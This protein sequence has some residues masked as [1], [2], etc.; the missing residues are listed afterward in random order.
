MK[1]VLSHSRTAT[2]NLLITLSNI[3]FHNAYYM[4]IQKFL[5]THIFLYCT[6]VHS[7]NPAWIVFLPCD[8]LSPTDKQGL[9]S[10]NGGFRESPSLHIHPLS[11][12]PLCL[13][14]QYFLLCIRLYFFQGECGEIR[15]C[16]VHVSGVSWAGIWREL[17]STVDAWIKSFVGGSWLGVGRELSFTTYSNFL[18]LL[19]QT[20]SHVFFFSSTYVLVLDLT[21]C[22]FSSNFIGRVTST[23]FSPFPLSFLDDGGQSDLM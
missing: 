15:D 12:S 3:L 16:Y 8:L 9:W 21:S 11:K 1:P 13:F 7:L 5:I 18:Y 17:V 19:F 4:N 23:N 6:N 14:F 10:H 20:V 2:W 22:I